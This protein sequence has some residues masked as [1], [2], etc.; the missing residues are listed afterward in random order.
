MSQQSPDAGWYDDPAGTGVQRWWN[1]TNWTQRTSDEDVV[2][3]ASP[4]N[5]VKETR[6]PDGYMMLNGEQVPLG[7][8]GIST[9]TSPSIKFGTA[10]GWLLAVGIVVVSLVAVLIDLTHW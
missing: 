3:T 9:P 5:A 2:T 8:M 4:S 7:T 6:L 1:G 10:L